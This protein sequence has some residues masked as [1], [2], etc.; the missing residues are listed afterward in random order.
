MSSPSCAAWLPSLPDGDGSGG[1]HDPLWPTPDERRVSPGCPSFAL[2][3]QGRP[4][5]A[6]SPRIL[7][8]PPD[9]YGIEYEINPWMDCKV[10]SDPAQ[11]LHQWWT[12][13]DTL[14]ELGA[15]VERLE[16]VAGLP[17]LVFTANAGLVY[18]K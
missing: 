2:N 10:G 7:M 17:D 1:F 6:E 16:P 14:G 13:H 4:L 5:M 8:C 15:T 12:L 11:S 18:R 9:F 3:P